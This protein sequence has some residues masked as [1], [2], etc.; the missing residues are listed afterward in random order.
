MMDRGVLSEGYRP[1]TNF[2]YAFIESPV[3]IKL[4]EI[5]LHKPTNLI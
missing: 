4:M 2:P 5:E 3:T 1:L